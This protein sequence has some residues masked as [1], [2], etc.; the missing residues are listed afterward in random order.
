MSIP[1][2]ITDINSKIQKWQFS[3]TAKT[4]TNLAVTDDKLNTLAPSWVLSSNFFGSN[5][6]ERAQR[7]FHMVLMF[8]LQRLQTEDKLLFSLEWHQIRV[9]SQPSQLEK[10]YFF[11]SGLYCQYKKSFIHS[12]S[13][14][15]QLS[16]NYFLLLTHLD[17]LVGIVRVA[18]DERDGNP[19]QVCWYLS[20]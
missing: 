8:D 17:R 3:K 7:W 2:G 15:K 14:R 19:G 16:T 6:Q 1:T 5:S 9:W 11:I 13:H 4:L 12:T 10:S 18:F 20:A